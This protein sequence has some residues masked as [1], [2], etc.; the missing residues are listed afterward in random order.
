MKTWAN[1]LLLAFAFTGAACSSN[2]V[3]GAPS[4]NL[5]SEKAEFGL[6]REVMQNEVEL[7]GLYEEKP[8]LAQRYH[9]LGEKIVAV[10]DR[11]DKPYEFILLDAD[12]FNAAAIPG[13]VMTYRGIL[14]YMNSEAELAMIMGHEVGHIAARHSARAISGRFLAQAAIIGLTAYAA[15]QQDSYLAQGA[16]LAS[17]LAATVALQGFSRSYE[18]EADTL[19]ER[20]L[21]KLGYPT[22][23]AYNVF[24][25]MKI[26]EDLEN[27][28][29][30]RLNGS[31]PEKPMFYDVLR[32]HP[33]PTS[34]MKHMLSITGEKPK[35]AIEYGK[36]QGD[37]GIKRDEYLNLIDGMIF[38]PSPEEGVMARTAYYNAEGKLKMTIPDGYVFRYIYNN[39]SDTKKGIWRGRNVKDNRMLILQTYKVDKKRSAREMMLSMSE[40]A[41]GVGSA[42]LG[43]RLSAVSNSPQRSLNESEWA[44]NRVERGH[45]VEYMIP[46]EPDDK[47][48]SETF[49]YMKLVAGEDDI[50]ASNREGDARLDYDKKAF[51]LEGLRKE[52]DEIAKT[53]TNLSEKEAE[54]LQ[55]LRI[56]VHTVKAGETAE[57]LADKMA[58]GDLREETL[59]AL[60]G[61]PADY[62]LKPGQKVK[63]VVNPNK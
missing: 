33:E 57:K 55:P 22:E 1:T 4:F 41:V 40:S 34:R 46:L 54:N 50:R 9:E 48:K 60:N 56:K 28:V 19:G 11:P 61:I 52:G 29:L 62:V 10:S 24:E 47:G 38:G 63:L 37:D 23:H 30:T 18:T 35:L 14:P 43:N 16:Y 39:S 49:L 53:L 32:S 26:Y 7:Y 51:D 20:Y 6:G 8:A 12:V 15:S 3:T 58:L 2:P 13:Y 42:K 59:R 21:G 5:L 36:A 45:S 25:M 44:W 27:E 31:V 17:G